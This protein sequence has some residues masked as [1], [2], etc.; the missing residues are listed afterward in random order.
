[1]P[2]RIRFGATF[3]EN[4]RV[5]LVVQQIYPG[6]PAARFHHERT[7]NGQTQTVL[8]ALAPGDLITFVNGMPVRSISDLRD[9]LEGQPG[10]SQVTVQG[11]DATY[12]WQRPF[13]GY[14]ILG[15]EQRRFENNFGA[16]PAPAAPVAPAIPLP[17]GVKRATYR[18]GLLGATFQNNEGVGVTVATVD[19][20]GPATRYRPENA[21]PDQPGLS[22]VPGDLILYANDQPVHSVDDLQAIASQAGPGGTL[23]IS[24]MDAS[25]AL[26][27]TYHGSMVLTSEQDLNNPA[28]PAVSSAPAPPNPSLPAVPRLN[29]DPASP[30]P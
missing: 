14:V 24:G 13:H 17:P 1:M 12:D 29:I 4:D 8:T 30:S 11:L 18:R 6:M 27:R 3:V 15:A 2:S 21:S 7:V 23:R 26:K 19:Q 10:G 5:G 20:N 22:L 28:A 9:M 16:A 25:Y